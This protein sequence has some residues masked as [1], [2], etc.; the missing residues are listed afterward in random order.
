MSSLVAGVRSDHIT[1]GVDVPRSL[2]VGSVEY[3]TA[4]LVFVGE[5][6]AGIAAVTGQVKV[7]TDDTPPSTWDAAD[8]TERTDSS[9]VGEYATLALKKLYTATT[10]GV[11]RLWAKAND[12]P[13]AP[14]VFCGTF[15][16]R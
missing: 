5:T 11:Y 14:V 13:E 7:T 6:A 2:V 3:V 16:V 8:V 15:T 10:A 1:G 9:P 4:E 12:N